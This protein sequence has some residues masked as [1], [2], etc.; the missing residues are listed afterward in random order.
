MKILL[1]NL[2]DERIVFRIS[3]QLCRRELFLARLGKWGILGGNKLR[4]SFAAKAPYV[5][6]V[7][8]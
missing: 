6:H 3:I 7:P 4:L 5:Y 2:A 1:S 8:H